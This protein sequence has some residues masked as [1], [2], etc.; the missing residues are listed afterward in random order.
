MER[1]T[2]VRKTHTS[3]AD[4]LTW[5]GVLPPDSPSSTSRSAVRS[6]QVDSIWVFVCGFGGEVTDEEVESLNKRF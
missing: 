1:K 4:L 6:H 2:P 3:T 5:S